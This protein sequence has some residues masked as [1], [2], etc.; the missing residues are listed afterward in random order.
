MVFP[1]LPRKKKEKKKEMEVVDRI[2]KRDDVDAELE[3]GPRIGEEEAE[4]FDR[5]R[6]ILDDRIYRSMP[7][8]DG[9]A[10]LLHPNASS[11]IDLLAVKEGRKK[12]A[13]VPG[14]TIINVAGMEI[15]NEQDEI[16]YSREDLEGQ[17]FRLVDI[18]RGD[19]VLVTG[20]NRWIA[21]ADP[22]QAWRARYLAD[23]VRRWRN[24][25][26]LADELTVFPLAEY[27]IVLGILLGY[28]DDDILRYLSENGF[29][30]PKGAC[31]D[32]HR[33]QIL[34]RIEALDRL[35]KVALDAMFGRWLADYE[36]ISSLEGDLTFFDY[37][38][39]I[40]GDLSEIGSVYT[41]GVDLTREDVEMARGDFPR[42]ISQAQFAV[43]GGSYSLESLLK[44]A[45]RLTEDVRREGHTCYMD[46]V[47]DGKRTREIQEEDEAD[48]TIS[49]VKRRRA[50]T[51][52]WLG[53]SEPR[54]DV[55]QD[56]LRQ[57]NRLY[58]A[59]DDMEHQHA[60]DRDRTCPFEV[61]KGQPAPVVEA[62]WRF[63]DEGEGGA[64]TAS[65]SII[66][67]IKKA[68][69]AELSTSQQAE[70]SEE[71]RQKYLG[72][73]ERKKTKQELD[74]QIARA[75]RNIAKHR[76]DVI[77]Y[78]RIISTTKDRELRGLPNVDANGSPRAETHE[79]T[80][81]ATNELRYVAE[82]ELRA[83]EKELDQLKRQRA[84]K[85][86]GRYERP[87]MTTASCPKK[88]MVRETAG[89]QEEA[90]RLYVA[91]TTRVMREG[92]VYLL[93]LRAYHELL[94][95]IEDGDYRPRDRSGLSS[96]EEAQREVLLAQKIHAYVGYPTDY[97]AALSPRDRAD[98]VQALR[99]IDAAYTEIKK[100]SER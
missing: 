32:A 70:L 74:A 24:S 1:L 76:A 52:S 38:E 26:R 88:V 48:R 79:E 75:E 47:S 21:Y 45:G 11:A 71:E 31:Y 44:M 64:V 91:L 49:L 27:H 99:D 66:T 14:R 78:D 83:S 92:H 23:H 67:R 59:A 96:D 46:G 87:A 35:E 68:V 72:G 86:K 81:A 30:W 51:L 82:N 28:S 9:G 57:A 80:I 33:C 65:A 16:S 25:V 19:F 12:I 8:R 63:I 69:G 42:P 50:S 56:I 73:R 20:Y 13:W 18:E 85:A 7:P 100:T 94:I 62:R 97:L 61:Q 39:R 84:G 2:L 10:G 40:R 58:D 90:N 77:K 4:F 41:K 22:K 5:I 98:T 6:G 43:D 36:N 15:A 54:F 93:Y 34:S 17:G 29:T 89:S 95:Q 3:A 60:Y 37:L 53:L 55:S